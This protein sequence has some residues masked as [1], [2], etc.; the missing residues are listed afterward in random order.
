MDRFLMLRHAP[1]TAQNVRDA[2]KDYCRR[3]GVSPLRM[4]YT[5]KLFEAYVRGL[6]NC[7]KWQSMGAVHS[8]AKVLRAEATR[9]GAKTAMRSMRVT[10]IVASLQK[11]AGTDPVRQAHPVT[12][13]E[14]HK[15]LKALHAA[16][17]HQVAALAAVTFISAI[18]LGEALRLATKGFT[19]KMEMFQTFWFKNAGT[20]HG[21]HPLLGKGHFHKSIKKWLITRRGHA[22]VFDIKWDKALEIINGHTIDG[23]TTN[24]ITGHSFRRGVL[25]AMLDLGAKAQ[26]LL[27]VSGHQTVKQ[28]Y[29]YLGKMPKDTAN[30]TLR[31]QQLVE[32]EMDKM[33]S[34]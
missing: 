1:G 16:G 28:L 26:E 4:Q 30:K 24:H 14:M 21:A 18:R 6:L 22:A 13:L 15:L 17:Q 29:Q 27:E 33:Q 10:A 11:M 3:T 34:N 5:V 8:R 31:L 23:H 20:A 7:P 19:A 32:D 2:I 25:R 12:I 9:Q